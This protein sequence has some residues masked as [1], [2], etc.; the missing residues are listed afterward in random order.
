MKT[1]ASKRETKNRYKYFFSFNLM[2]KKTKKSIVKE[3]NDLFNEQRNWV[4]TSKLYFIIPISSQP[5]GVN[6]NY[7]CWVAVV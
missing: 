2:I 3:K 1:P 7:N 5:D 4:V 6:S